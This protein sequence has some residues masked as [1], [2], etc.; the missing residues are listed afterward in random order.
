MRFRIFLSLLIAAPMALRAQQTS[1]T[2]VVDAKH[3]PKIACARPNFDFGNVDEGPDITHEFHC[4]NTGHGKLIVTGVSTSCGCTAAVAQKADVKGGA[5]SYPVT[6]APGEPVL[7]K[8]TY[9]TSGRPGHATK[10]ITVACND[11]SN[12]N[13]Q[14]KLDMTVVRDID[15]QPSE[16]L[17]LYGVKKGEKR[18]STI[19]I[20]GKPNHP[21]HVLSA[22]PK[23]G[24]VTVT[25]LTPFED[26]NEHRSGATLVVDLSEGLTI[27]GFT[28]EI[29]VKTDSPK[30][31]ELTISVLGEIRGNVQF[32]PKTLYFSPH[33]DVPVTVTFQAD[34]PNG[35]AIR[36]VKSANHLTRPH[37]VKTTGP[38][39]KDQYSVVVSCISDLPKDSD[40]KDQVLVTT[41]DPEMTQISIDAQVN[42]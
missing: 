14:L 31:P 1:T 11:P 8:A 9:H 29:L 19:K 33:Q 39:G 36:S 17:Y 12:P 34:N 21:L 37:V 32:N 38:D 16:H 30:K 4:K 23:N 25:S 22:T 6:F 15:I 42:K 26:P 2:P 35:F 5:P 20:L 3:A 10:I 7:I 27:G 41:N 28:D 24:T 40:G 13:F 18:T